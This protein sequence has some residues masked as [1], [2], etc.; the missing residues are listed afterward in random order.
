M[1][2]HAGA[3]RGIGD[4]D[5]MWTWVVG[6]VFALVLVAFVLWLE[7][8]YQ[9]VERQEIEVKI[10]QET[11]EELSLVRSQQQETLGSYGW[12]EPSRGI[13][14]IPVERAMELVERDLRA[15]R[16][17]VPAAVEGGS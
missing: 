10:I 15:G 7:A 5:T 3:G 4:P 2:E 16:P 9:N 1:S 12:V 6:I 11:P 8:F 14:R 13:A 17:A